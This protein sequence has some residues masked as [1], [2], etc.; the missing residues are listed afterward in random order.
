MHRAHRSQ[1]QAGYKLSFEAV[2]SSADGTARFVWFGFGVCLVRPNMTDEAG[3]LVLY[4]RCH[5]LTAAREAVD[6]RRAAGWRAT[7]TRPARA[8]RQSARRLC[9]SVQAAAPTTMRQRAAAQQRTQRG[10]ANQ[11][12]RSSPPTRL[13]NPIDPGVTYSCQSHSS[14]DLVVT[15]GGSELLL[16][17]QQVLRVVP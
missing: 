4:L 11:I 6:N 3:P 10:H 2:S 8:A 9:S 15:G 12:A 14:S 7:S 5:R 16:S 13:T 17:S 1:L